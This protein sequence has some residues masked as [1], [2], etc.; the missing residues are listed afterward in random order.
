VGWCALAAKPWCSFAVNRWCTSSRKLTRGGPERF[1]SSNW[2]R[3]HVER[4]TCSR[5]TLNTLYPRGDLFLIPS[6]MKWCLGWC[7]FHQGMR[8]FCW[9]AATDEQGRERRIRAGRMVRWGESPAGRWPTARARYCAGDSP[10]LTLLN[11]LAQS[12]RSAFIGSDGPLLPL[13]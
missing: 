9:P 3:T 10:H 1:G 11:D 6:C 7:F 13:P 12:Q 8:S 5:R 2:P 4:G